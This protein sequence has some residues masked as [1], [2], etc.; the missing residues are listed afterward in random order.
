MCHNSCNVSL[1]SPF[2]WKSC[3]L[4]F[5][6]VFA[7]V[8]SLWPSLKVCCPVRVIIKTRIKSGDFF[9]LIIAGSLALCLAFSSPHGCRPNDRHR[10]CSSR[11][12]TDCPGWLRLHLVQAGTKLRPAAARPLCCSRRS[13]CASGPHTASVWTQPH[14][15]R[16]S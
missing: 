8:F 2:P 15:N 9:F 7:F 13:D 6:H 5:W 12:A 3:Y 10:S 16:H 14:R 1:K 11:P 4:C